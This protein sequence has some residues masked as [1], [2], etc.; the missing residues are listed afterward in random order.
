MI[1]PHQNAVRSEGLPGNQVGAK[2]DP[3]MSVSDPSAHHKAHPGP[4]AIRYRRLTDEQLLSAAPIE[5]IVQA[6]WWTLSNE[7]RRHAA[8]L[9]RR[10][11][12]LW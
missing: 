4:S 7:Q 12:G 9:I 6:L 2:A 11:Q 3:L 1:P 5:T 10:L 8:D